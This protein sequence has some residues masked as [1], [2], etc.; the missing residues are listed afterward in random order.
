VLAPALIK[1]YG[2]YHY[3]SFFLLLLL[4]ALDKYFLSHQNN[5]TY[6]GYV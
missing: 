1:D 2:S 6:K 5:T 3:A 4:E